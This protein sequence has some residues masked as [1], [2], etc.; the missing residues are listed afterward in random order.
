[1]ANN[2]MKTDNLFKLHIKNRRKTK[3]WQNIMIFYKINWQKI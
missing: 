2:N 3:K 1:M